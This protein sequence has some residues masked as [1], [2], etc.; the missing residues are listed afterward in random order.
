MGRQAQKAAA[1]HDVGGRRIGSRY[2]QTWEDLAITIRSF[3]KLR[4][5]MGR[6]ER[7]KPDKKEEVRAKEE[8][9]RG[10]EGREIE[11]KRTQERQRCGVDRE[12][13]G[14]TKHPAR[15]TLLQGSHPDPELARLRLGAALGVVGSLWAE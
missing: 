6:E 8:I 3:P 11:A 12:H 5:R 2:P 7:R 14:R 15:E 1:T 10:T 4:L 9:A 13:C